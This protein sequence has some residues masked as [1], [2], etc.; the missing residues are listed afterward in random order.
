METFVAVIELWP[1]IGDFAREVGVSYGLAKQ[2][3]MRNS[4]PAAHWQR[5]IGAAQERGFE[6]V[7][8]ERLTE[9]AQL[10]APMTNIRAKVYRNAGLPARVG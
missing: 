2:W 3:R 8:A 5:V 7:T 10:R 9:I 4:I 1:S 6:G